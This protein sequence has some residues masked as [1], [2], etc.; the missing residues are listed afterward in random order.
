MLITLGSVGLDV[1][2]LGQEQRIP[3]NLN[4]LAAAW[5]L[6]LLMPVDQESLEEMTT[7]GR[8][9]AVQSGHEEATKT[10]LALPY[11]P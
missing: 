5:S 9:E 2:I 8:A 11:M 10:P 7:T 6:G 1:W 4:A 3:L